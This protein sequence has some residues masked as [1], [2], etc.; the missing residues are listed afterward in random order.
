MFQKREN[1]FV[2]KP[3]DDS[4]QTSSRHE[5]IIGSATGNE[6]MPERMTTKIIEAYTHHRISM[7]LR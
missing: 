1:L 6:P 7:E 3:I 2:S 5:V 4:L